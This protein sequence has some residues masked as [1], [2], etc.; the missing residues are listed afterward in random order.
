MAI[1]KNL[2]KV[3]HGKNPSSFLVGALAGLYPVLF[4]CYRN[5]G[6][7]N[8]WEHFLFFC[9][10]FFLLPIFLSLVGLV[11]LNSLSLKKY[12]VHFL[13]FLNFA[14]FFGSIIFLF[15][16]GKK[17]LILFASIIVIAIFYAF[18]LNK[19][20]KKLMFFQF[21]LVIIASFNLLNRVYSNYTTPQ[22]WQN[23]SDD[24]INAKLVHRPNIYLIQPDG[25]VNFSEYD[26][27]YYSFENN[28]FSSYL[29]SMGFE[30][31]D[32]FRSNYSSTL[33][34]NS[35]LMMMK[36]HYYF[37]LSK[38]GDIFDYRKFIVSENSVLKI[39]KNNGYKTHFIS[40]NPY[41]L[42]NH[43]NLGFDDANFNR[44]EIRNIFRW[45]NPKSD[46]YYDLKKLLNQPCGLPQF[47]FIQFFQPSHVAHRE[48]WSNGK[49]QEK[50]NWRKR[51]DQANT[52]IKKLIEIINEKDHN[53]LI[54][55]LS[56]HGGFVGF[57]FTEQVNRKT[58][59]RNL[60][61]SIFS[62]QLSIRW[63]E[64]L[65]PK[66]KLKIK[67]SVNVF[68]LIFSQLAEQPAFAN[69]L[70]ADESYIQLNDKNHNGIYKYIDNSNKVV[71]EPIN[72][73][74]LK[75]RK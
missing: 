53:A 6:L 45:G 47:Y 16:S 31:H 29:S 69:N 35:S 71:C 68:R 54:I 48:D 22:G 32:N 70:E 51:L 58:N 38:S 28:G 19:Q 10:R 63:P 56:D 61:Y 62:S 57:D 11:L 41:L 55:I 8:S 60:I 13:S 65:I 12:K 23:H 36:H 50:L 67:S 9:T 73:V 33:A 40:E 1:I 4:Y 25:Y 46:V 39:L 18:L 14:F 26:K 75:V 72:K 44:K 20:L 17:Q 2:I 42:A 7:V 66:S 21:L 49:E 34:S 59:D 37:H 15:F 43:P 24:I 52:N 64:D 74:D 27:G 30:N 3:L 5:F